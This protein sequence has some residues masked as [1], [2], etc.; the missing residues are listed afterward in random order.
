MV[1]RMGGSG[2]AQ[3]SPE[4]MEAMFRQQYAIE[5]TRYLLAILATAPPSSAAEF[6][7]VGDSDVDEAPADVLE[8]S[9]PN[10]LALRVFFDKKSHLPLLLSYRGPRPRVMTMTRQ[11][12]GTAE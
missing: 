2:G 6:K 3:P 8:V 12:G 9:G 5:M 1:I 7:Y 11:A 10:R 4:Q